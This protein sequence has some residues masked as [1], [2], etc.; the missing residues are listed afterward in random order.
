MEAVEQLSYRPHQ[1]RGRK[2]SEVGALCPMSALLF[3]LCL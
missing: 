3:A 1:C 2:L